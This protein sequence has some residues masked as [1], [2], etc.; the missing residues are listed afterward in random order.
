L[1]APFF[2]LMGWGL[3][4]LMAIA[5]ELSVHS[6][7]DAVGA[8]PAF[9]LVTL[10]LALAVATIA[11][12]AT[13]RLI[14]LPLAAAGL[15]SILA[16]DLPDVLVS[17]DGRLVAML[18]EENRLAVNRPRPPSFTMTNWLYATAASGVERPS[19][20]AR[21]GKGSERGSKAVDDGGTGPAAASDAIA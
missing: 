10:S 7:V 8:I 2:A 13:L 16:R 17:E 6:P 4:M 1:D 14:A 21:P 9:A 5:H 3:R 15:L 18:N 20:A 19:K 12:T 11:T